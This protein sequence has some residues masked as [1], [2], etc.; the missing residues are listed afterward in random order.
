M[1]LNEVNERRKGVN[2]RRAADRRITEVFKSPRT[3]EFPGEYA[4]TGPSSPKRRRMWTF[5]V[6][7][8]GAGIIG[9]V[10]L[11]FR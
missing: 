3:Y 1:T 7:G 6:V 9:F 2:E 8:F 10:L 5:F 4:Q 11:F